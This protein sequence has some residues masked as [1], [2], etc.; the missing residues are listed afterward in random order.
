MLG[1]NGNF[2]RK[3]I[4]IFGWDNNTEFFTELHF[5]VYVVVSQQL[6]QSL[7]IYDNLWHIYNVDEVANVYF[8]YI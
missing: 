3:S 2:L 8:N 1:Y 5:D 4:W 6:S 7:L